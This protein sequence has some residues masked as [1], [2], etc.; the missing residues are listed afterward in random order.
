MKSIKVFAPATVAN[1]ACGFDVMGFAINSP[2]DEVVMRLTDTKEVVITKIEGDNGKLPLVA[3]KNTVSITVKKYLEFFD[4]AQGVEIE[5]YKKMP[6]G[7]GLGS[8][9]A[10]AVAG[11]VAI[12]HLL[13]KRMTNKDLLP[14]A[15]EGER[16]A[17]GAAHADNVAPA[18]F[19]GFVVIRSY[20]PLDVLT[21]Q[22]PPNLMA[23]VLHPHIELRTE[24]SR[25]A[26]PK[27]IP[28]TTAVKQWGNVAGLVAGLLQNNYDAIRNSLQDF[29]A[30]PYRAAL[31]PHF[32]EV[33]ESAIAAGA[34]GSSISGS[35][36]SIFALCAGEST[37][38]HVAKAME[39]VMQKHHISHSIYISPI[40]T[41][42]CK[43]I[44]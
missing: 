18:L 11:L 7:S 19:G 40:N 5:L 21:I 26:L 34:L 25:N 28:L 31:I 20:S 9:A 22:T 42:G 6:L 41:E 14:F 12:N 35:G 13:G 43:I 17:C 44:G 1:V 36:P 24:D 29:V 37:A 33:K 15:M 16:L 27:N 4:I 10:S 39:S 3:E 23:V 2:G 32:Y 30:E 8:S 38:N